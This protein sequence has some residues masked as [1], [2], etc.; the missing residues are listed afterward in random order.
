[1]LEAL[2]EVPD[3]VPACGWVTVMA[4][5]PVI[6]GYD[7]FQTPV[8]AERAPDGAIR[9]RMWRAAIS[10]PG[11][12]AAPVAP[13]GGSVRHPAGP[14]VYVVDGPRL[15]LLRRER[16]LSQERLAYRAGLSVTAVARLE[17]QA[18]ASCRGHTLARLAAALR[19]EPAAIMPVADARPRQDPGRAD[20]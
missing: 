9:A 6:G 3:G 4:Y 5:V 1:M 17:R 19:E 8:R 10:A 14:Q 16:G 2:G 18:R 12:L 13:D 7:R 20:G 11:L 15:R